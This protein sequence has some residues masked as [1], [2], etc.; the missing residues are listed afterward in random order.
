[1]PT[2]SDER[3][4]APSSSERPT[5][6]ALDDEPQWLWEDDWRDEYAEGQRCPVCGL[7]MGDPHRY[8]RDH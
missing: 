1:M 7:W 3:L 4:P 2:H 5:G 8:V 6:A